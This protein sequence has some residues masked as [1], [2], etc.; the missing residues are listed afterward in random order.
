[1][2]LFK[3]EVGRPSNETIKKRRIAYLVIAIAIVSLVSGGTITIIGLLGD[4]GDIS[5]KS[6]NAAIDICKNLTTDAQ[7]QGVNVVEIPSTN[8]E[9]VAVFNR[10]DTFKVETK[11]Y[12]V[13]PDKTDNG[14]KFNMQGMAVTKNYIVYAIASKDNTVPTQIRFLNKKTK[15]VDDVVDIANYGHASDMTYVY[16]VDKNNKIINQKI[17]LVT[18]PKKLVVFIELDDNGKPKKNKNGKY[19]ISTVATKKSYSRIA[20]DTSNNKILLSNAKDNSAIVQYDGV[21]NEKVT[22][23]KKTYSLAKITTT[24]KAMTTL[25][26]KGKQSIDYNNGKVY[27]ATWTGATNTEKTNGF[28]SINIIKFDKNKSSAL[29]NVLYIKYSTMRGELEGVSIDPNGEMF[30]N[31]GLSALNTKTNK[32]V[33]WQNLG[34]YKIKGV[35]LNKTEMSMIDGDTKA[36]KA[37][38]VPIFS[39]E[40]ISWSSS[41]TSIATV[42]AAGVVKAEKAGTAIIT[43][44]NANGVAKSE[45][46]VIKKGLGDVATAADYSIGDS[47]ITECDLNVVKNLAAGK[48]ISYAARKEYADINRDGKINDKD[49]KIVTR[50]YMKVSGYNIGDVDKDK[51]VTSEDANLLLS[52]AMESKKPDTLQSKLADVDGNGKIDTED[53]RTIMLVSQGYGDMCKASNYLS[54]DGKITQA[55]VDA[56]NKYLSGSVSLNAEQKRAADVNQDGKITKDDATLLE[57]AMD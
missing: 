35:A 40:S 42:S 5:G 41:D 27:Y 16:N 29:E 44:K 37:T 18:T 36:L 48:S 49:E 13:I 24:N 15:K 6:K 3:N 4:N 53:A 22:I 38:V 2:G 26:S 9:E 11:E 51:K 31:I 12:K 33:G 21:S 1:M 45:I 50:L 57:N 20:Y 19:V 10:N 23:D 32:Y 28:N 54:S 25:C 17:V 8:L 43:A 56:I 55:D 52:F 30:I 47:K 34:F 46:T 39:N 7:R 14:N